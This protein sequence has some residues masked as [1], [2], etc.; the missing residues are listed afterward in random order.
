MIVNLGKCVYRVDFVKY[1][2]M[3]GKRC[4][5]IDTQC[6][7]FESTTNSIAFI[8][9]TSVFAVQNPKDKYDKITGKK[10]ALTRALKRAGFNKSNRIMFWDAFL[11][12]FGTLDGRTK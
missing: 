4:G 6:I 8:Q 3:Q 2:Q 7:I 9:K 5:C 1:Q 10:I 12:T 11:K